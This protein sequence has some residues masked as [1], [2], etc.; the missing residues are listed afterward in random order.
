MIAFTSIYFNRK[1]S[2]L[3]APSPLGGYWKISLTPT[4]L[5]PPQGGGNVVIVNPSLKGRKLYDFILPSWG[6]DK[7]RVN[8]FPQGGGNTVM[9][10]E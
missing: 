10:N 1:I 7:R 5:L 3:I 9:S 8:P 2:F 6:G 4:L